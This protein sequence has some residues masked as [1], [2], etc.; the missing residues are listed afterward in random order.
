[1]K[2]QILILTLLLLTSCNYK[3]SNTCPKIEI[4]A[5]LIRSYDSINSRVKNDSFKAYDIKLRITNKSEKR[6]SFWIM[7]CSWEFNFIINN[8]YIKFNGRGCDKNFLDLKHLNPN[9]SLVLNG[10]VRKV[11]NTF[12]QDIESTRFGFIYI[13]SIRCSNTS[14]YFNIVNDKSKHGSIIWSNPLSLK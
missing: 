3:K 9:E 13:D 2:I 14:E 8:D 6:I 11:E 7:T 4:N 10:L 1:M 5:T 12:G